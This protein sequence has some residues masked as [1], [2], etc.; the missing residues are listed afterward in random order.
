MCL[1]V[2]AWKTAPELPLLLAGNR[3]EYHARATAAL[4]WWPGGRIVAG[5][6][7]AAGGTW[8]GATRG[9]RFAVVT[10][11]PQVPPPVAARSRGRL[12]TDFLE[13]NETPLAFLRGVAAKRECYAGFCIIAGSDAD[14]AYYANP[15][16]EPRALGPGLHGLENDLIDRPSPRLRRALRSVE[17]TL[18]SLGGD[19]AALFAL[20]GESSTLEGDDAPFRQGPLYGTR[21]T[22]ILAR[23]TKQMSIAE[24]AYSADGTAGAPRAFR[25][26]PDT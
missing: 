17:A 9:G 5:R 3:D 12:V 14:A 25:W 19:Q 13:G 1:L 6:D 18:S 24:I 21:S 8:L 16:L 23:T 7:L 2:L 10:N 11:L 4:E 20:W 22:T 15:E 26:S